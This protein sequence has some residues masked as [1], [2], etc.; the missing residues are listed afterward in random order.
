MYPKLEEGVKKM[1][2]HIMTLVRPSAYLEFARDQRILPYFFQCVL[3]GDEIM[4]LGIPQ[5]KQDWR[6]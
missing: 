4:S 5:G 2:K 3:S 1:F 6:D